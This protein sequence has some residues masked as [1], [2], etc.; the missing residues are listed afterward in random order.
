MKKTIGLILMV[1]GAIF[2]VLLMLGEVSL[3]KN[4]NLPTD[5]AGWIGNLL[6]P[7]VCAVVFFVGNKLRK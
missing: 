3:A 7:V 1:V 4:G 2:F 6:L 5:L